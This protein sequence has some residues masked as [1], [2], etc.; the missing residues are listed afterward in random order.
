MYNVTEYI[1]CDEC[2]GTGET[3]C[4]CYGNNMNCPA[5]GGTGKAYCY[6]CEEDGWS[7]YD[8]FEIEDDEIDNYISSDNVK[9]EIEK[10]Y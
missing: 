3:R 10:I 9:Y 7:Y 1:R 4:D 2:S 5:C 6:N 8:S